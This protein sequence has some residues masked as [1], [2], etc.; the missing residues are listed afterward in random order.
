VTSVSADSVRVHAACCAVLYK[1]INTM[2]A[3]EK[4]V[5]PVFCSAARKGLGFGGVKIM[6]V[7]CAAG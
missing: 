2:H 6:D 5:P 4:E 3:C 7:P 1:I